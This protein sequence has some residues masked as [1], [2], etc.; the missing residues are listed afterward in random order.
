MKQRVACE[1]CFANERA[2]EQMAHH[3]PYASISYHILLS[4]L[5]IVKGFPS[6]GAPVALV[7]RLTRSLAPSSYTAVTWTCALHSSQSD[8]RSLA[9]SL[10]RWLASLYL[11][12]NS[13]SQTKIPCEVD[14]PCLQSWPLMILA[15]LKSFLT[16]SIFFTST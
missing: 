4:I 13:T 15:A 16:S 10:A 14:S 5:A 7:H 2:D 9:R 11:K 6:A 12:T 8:V 3:V 1:S